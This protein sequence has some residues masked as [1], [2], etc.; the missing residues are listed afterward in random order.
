VNE[1]SRHGIT[2]RVATE[3]GRY[4]GL[5]AFSVGVSRGTSARNA[6]ILCAHT[7]E[8]IIC[9]V[10]VPAVTGPEAAA[11][12]PIAADTLRAGEAV[13]PPSW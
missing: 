6:G 10:S 4:P 12:L 8:E 11:A 13:P 1:P 2:I 3:A 9:V 5:A 7:V